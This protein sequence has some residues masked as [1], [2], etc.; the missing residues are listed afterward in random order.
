MKNNKPIENET[1]HVEADAL[2]NPARKS[3]IEAADYTAWEQANV[4]N[5]PRTLSER[6][7]AGL[8]PEN[9]ARK[10]LIEAVDYTAWEQ[11][12]VFNEPRTLSQIEAQQ[13]GYKKPGHN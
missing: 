10:S 13:Y 1:P 9:P 4:F 7:A 8:P 3:L 11:E 2:E 6:E 5:E 12:N